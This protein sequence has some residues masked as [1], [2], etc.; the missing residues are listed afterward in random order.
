M[1]CLTALLITFNCIGHDFA[2]CSYIKF[3]FFTF[4]DQLLPRFKYD[5]TEMP[6]FEKQKANKQNYPA[7]HN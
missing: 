7:R 2:V 4:N 6:L 5:V 3:T 1:K